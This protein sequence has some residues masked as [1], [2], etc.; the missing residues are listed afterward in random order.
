MQINTAGDLFL[1]VG[2]VIDHGTQ[3]SKF[4]GEVRKTDLEIQYE[5]CVN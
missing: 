5:F 3:S 1:F 4:S 2:P